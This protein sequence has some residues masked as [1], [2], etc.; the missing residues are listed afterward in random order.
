MKTEGAH[1][2]RPKRL[3]WSPSM[4]ARYTSC[5]RAWALKYG[6]LTPFASARQGGKASAA[7]LPSL[8]KRLGTLGHYGMQAAYE[9]AASAPLRV[10]GATMDRYVAVA[11]E[12]I[13]A[14]AIELSID[15]MNV[16]LVKDDVLSTLRVLPVPLPAAV[17]GVER[18]VKVT[19]PGGTPMQGVVDLALRVG[20]GAVHVRDWKRTPL[21]KLPSANE[22]LRDGKM[23]FYAYSQY[24]T[25]EADRVSVGLYSLRDQREVYRDMP[26]NVAKAVVERQEAI[27]R[28]A[29]TDGVLR[30]TPRGGNCQDCL[31]LRSCPLWANGKRPPGY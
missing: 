28:T 23:G 17:L 13:D 27:I 18:K 15:E 26:F 8:P 16:A 31:V 20:R 24:A 9:V 22:L 3:V 29:E 12:R 30:P 4:V 21:A 14:M 1:R 6:I 10:I 2:L 19:L 11:F 25:G 7:P 5:P